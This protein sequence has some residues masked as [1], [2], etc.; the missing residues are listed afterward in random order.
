[1]TTLE[2]L[3]FPTDTY[4]EQPCDACG[5]QAGEPCFPL[6]V[7]EAA[8]VVCGGCG[9]HGDEPCSCPDR[10]ELGEVIYETGG[11]WS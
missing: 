9:A 1:M 10:D 7:G 8:L 2:A 3:W 4:L 5:A 6:C 11:E